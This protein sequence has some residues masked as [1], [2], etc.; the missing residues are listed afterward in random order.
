MT[1]DPAMIRRAF[2]RTINND[3][4]KTLNRVIFRSEDYSE[5]NIN[6]VKD[7]NENPDRYNA[8]LIFMHPDDV[9]EHT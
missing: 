1:N 4:H 2:N 5:N 9:K 7:Q 6:F 8:N 3:A